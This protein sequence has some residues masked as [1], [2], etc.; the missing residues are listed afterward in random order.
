MNNSAGKH[1]YFRDVK[2]EFKKVIRNHAAFS[3]KGRYPAR[4]I[5]PCA[6]TPAPHRHPLRDKIPSC[7]PPLKFQNHLYGFLH[8]LPRTPKYHGKKDASKILSQLKASGRSSAAS[9][10]I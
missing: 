9:L 8:F 10:S 3:L 2:N 1:P 4:G 6:K 7:H 5:F